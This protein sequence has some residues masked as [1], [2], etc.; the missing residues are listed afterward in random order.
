[1]NMRIFSLTFFCLT[2]IAQ[3]QEKTLDEITS[4]KVKN[5]GALMDSKNDVDGYYFFYEVDKLKKGMK[6]YAI[7]ILDNNLNDIATKSYVDNKNTILAQSK[8]NNQALLF[9]MINIKERQYKLISF[10][11]KAEKLDEIV[12]PVDKK[13]MKYLS[14]M[15]K[16][17]SFNLLYPVDNK[18]FLFT[19]V[20]DNKKL[21]Y[22]LKYVATD[23]GTSWD[24]NSPEESKDI[25][26]I[27][28]I[29]ATEDYVIALQSSK[30]SL[31]T[32]KVDLELIVIDINSGKKLFSEAFERGENPRLIT[33]VFVNKEKQIIAL[34]E[35]FN[36]KDNI[37]TDES[38]GLFL[39][40]LDDSGKTLFENKV[41]WS[42]ID[43]YIPLEEGKKRHRGYI[44]FH[45]IMRTEKGNYV[46]VGEKYRKTISLKGM[47]LNS[48]LGSGMTQL[49]I[50]DALF[51][52]FDENFELNNIEV[53][54]KGKSRVQNS[55]DFGSP[56]LNAHI[57]K[58]TGGFDYLFTQIDSNRDRF[59]SLFMDY[60]R[61]KG[62]KNKFAF[63]SVI[64][65]D[66]KITE[67]K[68]Y[69]DSDFKYS[70]TRALPGKIGNVMLME[71]NRK[72]KTLK[73]HLEQL[74]IQ[75]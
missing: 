46:A 32:K 35:Y 55:I 64:Y 73:I 13:E 61:I 44:Y 41:G 8:F 52:E 2:L 56:Q 19:Y 10:D 37:T 26:T 5:S 25:L 69:L 14:A 49:T 71:Y 11:R 45:D 54:E 23:G 57:I 31:I 42:A 48:Q 51:A 27:N 39:K 15:V 9:A 17:G 74:N 1:M 70:T 16:L 72:K 67:D 24:F 30:S 58:A 63:K 36:A 53:V 75:D 3:A 12:I 38:Q 7:K 33:N 34:G 29:Q 28:P 20:K 40:A 68:V 4:F 6:E 47:L 43:K 59:Y 18:G 21:G 60:E 50:T 22:G 65:N 62:E 66:D